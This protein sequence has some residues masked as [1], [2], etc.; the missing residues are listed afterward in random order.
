MRQVVC[1]GHATDGGEPA[2][3]PLGDSGFADHY[4]GRGVAKRHGHHA[5]AED[6]HARRCA[7]RI[8]TVDKKQGDADNRQRESD[9]VTEQRHQAIEPPR[10]FGGERSHLH[11][12]HA[13]QH[14]PARAPQREQEEA[15]NLEHQDI[16]S[17]APH[18]FH[19][20]SAVQG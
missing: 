18:D 20:T 16:G 5:Q 13:Q 4:D 10:A 1:Q 7:Q 17:A 9:A 12:G 3:Q 19:V 14:P 6:Q 8:V 2:C 11:Q 15:H